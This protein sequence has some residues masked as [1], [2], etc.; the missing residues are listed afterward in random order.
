MVQLGFKKR[1]F[2]VKDMISKIFKSAGNLLLI[3]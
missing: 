1:Q 2:Q 3:L